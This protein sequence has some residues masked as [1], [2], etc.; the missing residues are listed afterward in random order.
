LITSETTLRVEEAI[1]NNDW[2]TLERYGRFLD[3][4]LKHVASERPSMTNQI[5]RVREKIQGSFYAAACR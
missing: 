1:A 4:I 2:P 3:P 5:D